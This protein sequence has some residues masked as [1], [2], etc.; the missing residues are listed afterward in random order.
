MLSY[1]K[2]HYSEILD[3][4]NG[5]AKR[6]ITFTKEFV[7]KHD[8][9]GIMELEFLWICNHAPLYILEVNPRLTGVW[10]DVDS[11]DNSPYVGHVIKPYIESVLNTKLPLQEYQWYKPGKLRKGI[12]WHAD[13]P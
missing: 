4:R 2:G 8:V 3:M 5:L 1:T 10:H 6:L 11:K 7:K 9:S 13:A 12:R